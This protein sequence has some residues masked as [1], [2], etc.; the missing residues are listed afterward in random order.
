LL[1]QRIIL[2]TLSS[3]GRAKIVSHFKEK[4]GCL[5]VDEACQ[6]TE[7]NILIPFL[8]DPA[9][10]FW[11]EILNSLKPQSLRK[12]KILIIIEVFSKDFWIATTLA[13][14]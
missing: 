1:K 6:T 3:S 2:S 4:I 13:I 12:I 7:P 5:I 11:L 10:L 14:F 9:R 8:Y